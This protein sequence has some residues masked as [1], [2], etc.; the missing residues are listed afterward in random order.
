MRDET[1]FSTYIITNTYHGT[2]YCGHTDNLGNRMNA[3]KTGHLPGFASKYGC[4][5]LVWYENFATRHEAFVRERRIKGWKRAWKIELIEAENPHWVDISECAYWPIPTLDEIANQ[6]HL[7]TH[8]E[9]AL[10]SAMDPSFRWD[11]RGRVV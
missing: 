11:E 4:R 6:P 3:H 2:L 7:L 10:A 8:R 9:R 5:H 1:V